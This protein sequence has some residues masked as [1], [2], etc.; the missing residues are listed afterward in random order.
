[1]H[2]THTEESSLLYHKFNQEN[3]M[4]AMLDVKQLMITFPAILEFKSVWGV[5]YLKG[6]GLSKKIAV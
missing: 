3:N 6:P 4:L 5:N 2:I 1:M